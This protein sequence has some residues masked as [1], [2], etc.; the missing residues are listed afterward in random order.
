MK[1]G[2]DI[3]WPLWAESW[4]EHVER[5]T[6][7]KPVFSAK[8]CKGLKNI[9]NYFLKQNN[10]HTGEFNTEDE[11]LNCFKYILSN[12]HRLDKFKQ[13]NYDTVYMY[14]NLPSYIKQL[15]EASKF[16]Q[17]IQRAEEAKINIGDLIR[18][19]K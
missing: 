11:A 12:W 16:V 5:E 9:R 2:K 8:E 6:G 18:S 10:K 19:R 14:S 7:V 13:G 3:Y 1:K 4:N 17:A 15:Q